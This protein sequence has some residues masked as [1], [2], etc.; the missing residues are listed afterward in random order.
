M[1]EKK[2]SKKRFL[3]KKNMSALY[4]SY[5]NPTLKPTEYFHQTRK[6]KFVLES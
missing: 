6:G 5:K 3:D 2:T 1:G 4:K